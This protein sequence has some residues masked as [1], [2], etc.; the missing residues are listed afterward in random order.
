[1]TD[2]SLAPEGSGAPNIEQPP[3]DSLPRPTSSIPEQES[4][5]SAADQTV[6]TPVPPSSSRKTAGVDAHL[7]ALGW[8]DQTSRTEW[9]LTDSSRKAFE[10]AEAYRRTSR[11]PS[12]TSEHVAL[13]LLRAH[14]PEGELNQLLAAFE[15]DPNEFQVTLQLT[16]AFERNVGQIGVLD[17]TTV[18][19][20]GLPALDRKAQAMLDAAWQLARTHHA[21]KTW[22][23]LDDMFGGLLSVPESVAYGVLEDTLSP[24]IV[25]FKKF[26]GAYLRDLAQ[27]VP[28][29]QWLAGYLARA[30]EA[31]PDLPV[32]L[33]DDK[34][35][36][37]KYAHALAMMARATAP[38]FAVGVF[39]PWGSGKS[40]IL[41]MVE[42][43][44]K[45]DQAPRRKFKSLEAFGEF[46]RRN[47][48]SVAFALLPIF[49]ATV[50][51]LIAL[52][53]LNSWAW[54]IPML[55][56]ALP[57]VLIGVR[58]L[59]RVIRAYIGIFWSVLTISIRL[60]RN[61]GK[62]D[63]VE[64]LPIWFNAWEH[65]DSNTLWTRLVEQVYN[66]LEKK[67]N[68]WDSFQYIYWKRV[69]Q[70]PVLLRARVPAFCTA[71]IVGV[72]PAVIT[73][74]KTQGGLVSVSLL[75][76][77]SLLP[78]LAV[79]LWRPATATVKGFVREE[80]F[81]V[82]GG[83]AAEVKSDLR[84]LYK[85]IT[86]QDLNRSDMEAQGISL[87]SKRKRNIRIVVLIDDLDRCPPDKAVD[88]LEAIKVILDEPFF[89]VFLAVDTRML[90]KAIEERYK[91]KLPETAHPNG[92]GMEYL[93]KIIQVPFW[94]P[95]PKMHEYV[96]ALLT[97]DG[98]PGDADEKQGPA[99]SWQQLLTF[100]WRITR[101]GRSEEAVSPQ[102]SQQGAAGPAAAPSDSPPPPVTS[103]SVVIGDSRLSYM[104]LDAAT[105]IKLTGDEKDKIA[106]YWPYFSTSP[107]GVKRIVNLFW[108]AKSLSYGAGLE[109]KEELTEKLVK[110]IVLGERWPDFWL[111]VYQYVLCPEPSGSV[112]LETIAKDKFIPI[113][114][115]NLTAPQQNGLSAE[116]RSAEV[117]SARVAELR[118]LEHFLSSRPHL[119]LE[120]CSN[121]LSI[122][123]N[124]PR[125]GSWDSY[126]EALNAQG[127]PPPPPT[128]AAVSTGL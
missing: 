44:I 104:R 88:I 4:Q 77:A 68:F 20:S 35:D 65:K 119:T 29:P 92:P 52:L 85:G 100:I 124:L 76:L 16:S 60:P 21:S 19:L 43:R 128:T 25:E 39:G 106:G 27:G 91:G 81:D 126:R 96:K 87:G 50:L 74:Y 69:S 63:R 30:A 114:T 1:M 47:T 17:V 18:R 26:A 32:G 73:W 97:L 38:P 8:D 116:G 122:T 22:V 66:E 14:G 89:V 93:E 57:L 103:A 75:G 64:L 15:I 12:V 111:Y 5:G 118:L 7:V 110:L 61:N 9:N 80:F 56:V 95:Q 127:S 36:M 112:D 2:E 11:E 24:H 51:V 107:R 53:L 121:L 90:V 37:A 98:R 3:P 31:D 28:F 23:E 84:F 34:L 71:L 83:L 105:Q 62:R 125:I 46:N 49:G 94:L 48:R 6:Q 79:G 120:D 117:A 40:S 72:T 58:P 82:E 54:R 70:F 115:A 113:S 55:A 99:S 42:E 45:L 102:S 67:L 123:V 33:D 101:L 10:W 78:S 13:G 59:S 108:L 41:K 86:G 109:L